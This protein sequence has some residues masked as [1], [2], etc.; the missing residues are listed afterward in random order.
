MAY[1][2]FIIIWIKL[3]VIWPNL[4]NKVRDIHSVAYFAFWVKTYMEQLN[5]VAKTTCSLWNRNKLQTWWQR[6]P[7]TLSRRHLRLAPSKIN[8]QPSNLTDSSKTCLQHQHN[9][10]FA[11]CKD[12]YK[13]STLITMIMNKSLEYR[14]KYLLWQYSPKLLL[15]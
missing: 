12:N 7:S 5:S 13:N 9:Y 1:F 6:R 2:Q 15:L 8:L 3:D 10:L 4:S 11:Q 14:W